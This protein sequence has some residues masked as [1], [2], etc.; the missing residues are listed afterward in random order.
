MSHN[1]WQL[2][3]EVSRDE[4][5]VLAKELGLSRTTASVL[6]RRGYADPAEA[7]RFLE[8]ERPAHDPLELGDM[9][10]ACDGIRASIAAGTKIGVHGDYD[11]NGK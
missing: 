8:A 11:E 7:R 4:V 10:A 5:D 3:G 1:G 9:A 2:R 6:V